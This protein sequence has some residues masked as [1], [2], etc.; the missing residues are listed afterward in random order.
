VSEECTHTNGVDSVHSVYI[1]VV[2]FIFVVCVKELLAFSSTLFK[3]GANHFSSS[4]F[5][6]ILSHVESSSWASILFLLALNTLDGV[7][8]QNVLGEGIYW[9]VTIIG[10]V[11]HE[12][13]WDSSVVGIHEV[14]VLVNSTWELVQVWAP[15]IKCICVFDDLVSLQKHFVVKFLLVRLDLDGRS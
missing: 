14:S 3:V 13:N 2:P 6:T 5:S 4:Q 10:G 8:C 7:V 11:T 12:C 15:S 1:V 9:I